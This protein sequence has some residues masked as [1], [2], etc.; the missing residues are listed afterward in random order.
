M[1]LVL[2]IVFNLWSFDNDVS[3]EYPFRFFLATA[4]NSFLLSQFFLPL[5]STNHDICLCVL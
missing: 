5:S 3:K 4:K 1:K 2:C